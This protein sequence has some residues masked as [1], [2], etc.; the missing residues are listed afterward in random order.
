MRIANRL[1]NLPPYFFV[2]V[3][4]RVAEKRAAG[5]DIVNLS[6]GNP[7]LPPPAYIIEA[8]YR[9][10]QNP[11]YHGY[12]GYYGIPAFREAVAERYGNRFNVELDPDREVLALIGSKEGIAN[13][14]L[15][16]IDPGDVALTADPGYPTY[17]M[18]TIIAG[19]EPFPLPLLKENG[20]LPD[21][22][23]IPHEVA[24]R[25]KVMWLNYPNNPTGATAAL[26]FFAQV[27][28][29]ARRYDI[30]VVHDNPYCE[31]TFEGYVAP[32]FLEVTGAKEV[33]MELNSLSK[34][35]NMAGWR[36]GMAVGNE[37]IIA[38]LARTKSNV[39]SGIFRP[40]QEA[41][42]VALMG[43]Q[44]WIPERNEIYQRRR[45]IMLEGLEAAGIKAERPRASLY[46]WAEVPEG[47]TS[48]EFFERLL[49]EIGVVMAPGSVY[50]RYGEGYMRISLTSPEERLRLAAERLALF[51]FQ[52]ILEEGP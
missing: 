29:F 46:I 51:D 25:A 38:A 13:T 16:L 24:Q 19:G 49:E 34:T 11:T 41:A 32:S 6:M 30:V 21:L 18:G 27:V 20:F 45:D 37:E 15:A 28:D 47:Y 31:L 14:T 5:I 40:L 39:D 36:V 9:A 50:G 48:V 52:D 8:L 17:R 44:S 4:R 26:D 23:S 10:A 33:G 2:G 22:S 43:D 3:N 35:Y 1:K 12:P 7:D 42:V